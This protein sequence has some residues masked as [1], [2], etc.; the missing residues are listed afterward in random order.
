MGWHQER[1]E[2]LATAAHIGES[3]AARA[4]QQSVN[5]A[6]LTT[7]HNERQR[8]IIAWLAPTAYEVDYYMKDLN[9]ARAARFANTCQWVF[10]NDVFDQFSKEVAK[11]GSL[12]WIYAQ[13]GAGKTVLSAALVDYYNDLQQIPETVLYFFCKD[14][15]SDKNTSSV[16]IRSLLYQLFISLHKRALCSSIMDDID[17][18]MM[19]SGQKRATDF[20]R[21][22]NIFSNHVSS[23]GSVAIIIDALDE[24]QDSSIL[25]EHF[26]CLRKSHHVTIVL[27]SRKE[28][29]IFELLHQNLFLEIT[30][31]DVDVDVR[32]FVEAKV[33]A[34]DFLSNPSVRDLIVQRLCES[35]QGM[36]L[37]VYLTLKELKS[38]CSVS[39]VQD[40]LR[41]LPNG[42]S[43]VYGSIL[44]RLGER[45]DKHSLLLCFKVLTWMVTAIVSFDSII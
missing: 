41:E 40:D 27:T 12:L 34:S 28:S 6:I 45:F 42:L 15:D 39:Q 30:A 38:C 22:W 3:Q 17:E 4:Q 16:I 33:K 18:A 31:D 19:N 8:K 9:S 11:A 13:P 10:T 23:F 37:W 2:K 43:G 5:T 35:H 36:F 1:V 26:Q 21:M 25:I 44:K 24:C 7:Q 32:N 20:K 29:A 14:T